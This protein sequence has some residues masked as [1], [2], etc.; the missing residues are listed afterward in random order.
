MGSRDDL[1]GLEK[2]ANPSG[3]TRDTHFVRR[4]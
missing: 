1:A 2:M 3:V 4:A